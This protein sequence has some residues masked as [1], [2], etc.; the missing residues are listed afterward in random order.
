MFR[1]LDQAPKAA[2]AAANGSKSKRPKRYR[3]RTKYS[4]ARPVKEKVD[5]DSNANCAIISCGCAILAATGW[6]SFFV[7]IETGTS[8][9]R[10]IDRSHNRQEVK[11]MKF[12]S[13]LAIA[14][15]V[16]LL[17]ASAAMAQMTPAKPAAPAAPAAAKPAAPAPAMDKMA[18]SKEC[19]SQA[20]AKN[21]HGKERKKF[22]ESCKHNG[23]KAAM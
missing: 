10:P 16:A 6:L 11:V 18:I 19:S 7:Q 9:S 12:T 22:R 23:G 4:F 2:A 17:G 20:D 5:L 13:S 8:R 14:G 15:M 3:W 21:L 1:G